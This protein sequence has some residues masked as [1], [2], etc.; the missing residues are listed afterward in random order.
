MAKTPVYTYPEDLREAANN[1]SQPFMSF[2]LKQRGSTEVGE[3][4]F[5][6]LPA[7]IQVSDGASYSGIE[8]GTV[9]GL[10]SLGKGTVNENDVA[11]KAI[12]IAQQA[13]GPGAAGA[14]EFGMSQGLALN[15][16]TNMA[17][18]GMSPRTWSFEFKLLSESAEESM[19]IKNI[20]NWF[21]KNMYAESIGDLSLK[22]PPMM[23][24]QF[25][26]GEAES[27]FLPMVM[28]SYV[29][30]LSVSYNESNSM[31]HAD[32]AP[33]ETS[34]SL[35]LSENKTLTK[36]DLYLKD[37][38]EYNRA[39]RDDSKSDATDLEEN[40]VKKGVDDNG[41]PI[42]QDGGGA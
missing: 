33:I 40:K 12:S 19:A 4:V 1:G 23:R 37:S 30:G 39:G 29:T 36:H 25:W 32:G 27:K 8:L 11:A 9:K 2:A 24:V 13:G 38:L 22:Y 15:P 42:V 5:M 31:Y 14:A 28:D 35:S 18:E 6:Y 20:E 41:N 26:E 16:F 7:S 21:R 3:M 34:I 10:R 17:F